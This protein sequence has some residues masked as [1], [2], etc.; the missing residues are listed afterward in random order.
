M[1]VVKLILSVFFAILLFSCAK[2]ENKIRIRNNFKESI[3]SATVGDLKFYSVRSASVSEYKLLEGRKF[4]ISIIT[5]SEVISGKG[6]INKLGNHKWTIYL[7][8]TVA[9]SIQEE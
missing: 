6:R 9:I 7:N 5:S 8:T 4:D 2:P 3:V 1:K